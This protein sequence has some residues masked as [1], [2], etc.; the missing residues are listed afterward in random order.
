MRMYEA[1][2][3]ESIVTIKKQKEGIA[4]SEGIGPSAPEK[5]ASL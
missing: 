3:K 1:Y 2:V 4:P 5:G